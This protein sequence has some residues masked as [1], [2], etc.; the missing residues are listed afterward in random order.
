MG[1]TR[2]PNYWIIQSLNYWITGGSDVFTE[3]LK[4]LNY[5]KYQIFHEEGMLVASIENVQINEWL[6]GLLNHYHYC[7]LLQYRISRAGDM[8]GVIIERSNNEWLLNCED[9]LPKQ[10]ESRTITKILKQREVDRHRI[11]TRNYMKLLDDMYRLL[12]L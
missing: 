11:C 6:P 5:W 2:L 1:I 7:W 12:K 9:K 4:S 3:L 8:L 10:K